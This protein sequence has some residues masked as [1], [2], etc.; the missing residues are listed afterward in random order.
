MVFP[1]ET[2]TVI[3]ILYKHT[4]TMIRSPD[5]DTDFF[6]DTFMP[7]LLIICLE[8]VLLRLIDLIK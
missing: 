4:K 5:G 6:E 3:R 1:K 8:Y 7:Y 2:L